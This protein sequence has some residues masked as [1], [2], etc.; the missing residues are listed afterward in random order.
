[1]SY[2]DKINEVKNELKNNNFESAISKLEN[3]LKEVN[4]RNV[5]N[6]N[7]TYYTFGNY[8]EEAIFYT[9]Y[10]NKKKNIYPEY[11][12]SEIYYLLGFVNIDLKNYGLAINYLD[13]ALKWNPINVAAMFEK[14]TAF[15]AS[16]N[17]ERFKA[18]VEKT[19]MY[20]YNSNYLSKYYRELGWYFVERKLFGLGNALY[21][22]SN[23]FYKTDTAENELKYIAQQENRKVMY[24]PITEITQYLRDYNI[25]VNFH[26]G[27]MDCIFNGLQQVKDNIEKRPIARYFS[28]LMYDMTLRKDFVW[29]EPIKNEKYGI[30]MEKP[31]HW[32]I[33]A[34]EFYE[35]YGLNDNTVFAFWAS[36]IGMY[37]V[38]YVGKCTN[39]EFEEKYNNIIENLKN[40]GVQI[41]SQFL[42]PK[43][44]IF[45]KIC[46]ERQINEETVRQNEDYVLANNKLFKISWESKN[47]KPRAINDEIASEIEKSLK[48]IN[49]IV[50]DKSFNN[51]EENNSIDSE[52]QTINSEFIK[53]GLNENLYNLLNDFSR[54]NLKDDGPDPFW[55]DY[56]RLILNAIL[57]LI[58]VDK[59]KISIDEIK[60]KSKDMNYLRKYCENIL[61]KIDI[62]NIQHFPELMNGITTIRK[63]DADRTMSSLLEIIN[64]SF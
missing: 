32:Q 15:R 33:L 13:E 7:N 1:M 48:T 52:L 20:I 35:K 42:E 24:T 22:Y 56:A 18:E 49:E 29:L 43:E 61:P 58:L 44:K 5:E 3:M 8:A 64:K 53:N 62:V 21:T 16:G 11:N 63:N 55:K 59:N 6:E 39:S 28:N 25:P 46:V 31:D 26:K 54:N 37:T 41:L 23:Y 38:T 47:T 9:I 19:Y 36:Q 40:S 10:G 34:K 60:E 30:Q 14:A 12:I 51:I 2:N 57:V 27:I 50:E 17:I 45:G 4:E